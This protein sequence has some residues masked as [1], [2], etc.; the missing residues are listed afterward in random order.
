MVSVFLIKYASVILNVDKLKVKQSVVSWYNRT[1][2]YYELCISLHINYVISFT[3][4]IAINSF[5]TKHS[6]DM[7]PFAY[8]MRFLPTQEC[9]CLFG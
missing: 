3:K 2:V 6:E 7:E 8:N 1:T 4:Q 9:N 5:H